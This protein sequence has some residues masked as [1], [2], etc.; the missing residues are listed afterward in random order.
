MAILKSALAGLRIAVT[1]AG[2]SAVKADEYGAD[3]SNTDNIAN[4]EN[5]A[6][7][8]AHDTFDAVPELQL[9]QPSLTVEDYLESKGIEPEYEYTTPW[10]EYFIDIPAAF[11]LTVVWHETG[12]Y[13]VANMFGY[14]NV[15]MHG[16]DFGRG[17]MASVSWENANPSQL[18]R[19]LVSAAGVGFTTGANLGLTAL[20]KNDI[21]PDWMRP[22][23]ATT[24]L[25]MMADRHRYIWSAA[26]KH[27]A[28]MSMDANDIESIVT[29]NFHSIEGQDAAYGVLVAASAIELALRWEE[30]SYL[31]R[32][33]IGQEVKVPEGLDIMP[34]L[35]PYGSTLMLGASGEF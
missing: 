27:W 3:L 25:M 14:E 13:I 2:A 26:I 20:L 9:A 12:H 5:I 17:L 15:Q 6:P 30:I 32:T 28:G 22:I 11:V 24:S 34:G 10:W 8:E 33:A 1:L 19:T 4:T 35:Y 31:V 23:T 18:Q 16:P 21:V 7:Y 29:T